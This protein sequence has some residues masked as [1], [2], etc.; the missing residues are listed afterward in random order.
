MG[1]WGKLQIML[2]LQATWLTLMCRNLDVMNDYV[3]DIPKLPMHYPNNKDAC[4]VKLAK[5]NALS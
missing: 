5:Q 3:Y 4:V 1:G 2:K